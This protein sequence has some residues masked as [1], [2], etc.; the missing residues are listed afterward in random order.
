MVK[1]K[2]SMGLG[3]YFE[4]DCSKKNSYKLCLKIESL[5]V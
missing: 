2:G 5:L 1:L 3:T 4:V